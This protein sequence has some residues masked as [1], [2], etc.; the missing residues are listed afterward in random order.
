[1][2]KITSR[3]KSVLYRGHEFDSKEEVYFSWYVKELFKAGVIREF[4]Y[5]PP[6]LSLAKPQRYA[7]KAEMKTKVKVVEKSL[8]QGHE[9]T[10]D[11]L[12]I[13]NA[14]MIKV[15]QQELK[16]ALCNMSD[17][18]LVSSAYSQDTLT[19]IS[20]QDKWTPEWFYQEK[21]IWDCISDDKPQ[22]Y[23]YVDVKGK[24]SRFNSHRYFEITRK[25][26]YKEHGIFINK[27][28]PDIHFSKTFCPERFR[29]TDQGMTTRIRTGGLKGISDII[30]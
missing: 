18:Y 4:I 27:V 15:F 3:G 22:L 29:A 20:E 13:W 2:E 8:I 17:N 23:S 28:V 14:E 11:W 5:Q 24:A 19:V 21:Y 26:I 30:G 9:Y 1:M 25:W 7:H 6:K 12:I 16:I 10:P